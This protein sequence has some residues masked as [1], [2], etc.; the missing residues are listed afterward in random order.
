MNEGRKLTARSFR[1][2]RSLVAKLVKQEDYIHHAQEGTVV[3]VRI[4]REQGSK[5]HVLYCKILQLAPVKISRCQPAHT[6]LLS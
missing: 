1:N 2:F 6:T 3:I 5:A 4:R